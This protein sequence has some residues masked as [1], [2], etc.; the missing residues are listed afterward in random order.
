[1]KGLARLWAKGHHRP[2]KG[3]AHEHATIPRS[4]LSRGERKMVRP[5]SLTRVR[6]NGSRLSLKAEGKVL[7]EA[8]NVFKCGPGC[9]TQHSDFLRQQ[10]PSKTQ[11]P[12]YLN[13]RLRSAMVR[14]R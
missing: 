2:S 11:P 4:L 8:L 6:V 13:R 9:M 12:V 14:K 10:C 5:R 7:C 3:F 1:L